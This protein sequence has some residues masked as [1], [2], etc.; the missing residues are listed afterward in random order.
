MTAALVDD[1]LATLADA[2]VKARQARHAFV[3]FEGADQAFIDRIV[4]AM[5]QAGTA[6]AAEL[7][8]LAVD[9]TGYGVYE[10]KI[11]KNKYNTGFVARWML[12]RRAVGCCGSTRRTGSR[13]SAPRWACS[14]GS[15]R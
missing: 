5:A 14:P 12:E 2:R 7:A 8:R 3:E 13:R 4:R 9:E 1:D 6:A 10:H 15:S 11:I